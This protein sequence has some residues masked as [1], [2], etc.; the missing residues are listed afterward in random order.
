M[1]L[2]QSAACAMKSDFPHGRRLSVEEYERGVVALQSTLP[3]MPTIEQDRAARRA[4]LNLNIDHR[5]GV[6]F[7]SE[8]REALWSIQEH[9]EKKRLTLVLWHLV[10]R[11]FRR[12]LERK[13]QGLARLL[14]KEYAKVLSPDELDAY[15]GE[16][17]VKH[18][19]LPVP[20]SSE[21]NG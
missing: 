18:P 16:E 8:R 6:D 11:V 21:E 12:G 14:I 9:V 17:E 13:A 3:P 5:L 2:G 10:S 4:E 15:F 1:L 19:L 20:G 7:P